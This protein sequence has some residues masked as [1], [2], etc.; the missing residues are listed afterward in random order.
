MRLKLNSWMMKDYLS[1]TLKRVS[2]LTGLI[3]LASLFK[4]GLSS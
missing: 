4:D 1:S 3:N 2:K